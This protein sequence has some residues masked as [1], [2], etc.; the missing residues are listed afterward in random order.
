MLLYFAH[1][2][3]NIRRTRQL[4]REEKTLKSFLDTVLRQM[5]GIVIRGAFTSLQSTTVS[6]TWGAFHCAKISGN[7]GRN[8]NGTLGSRRKFSGKSGPPPE[9]VLFD[10]SIRSDRNLPFRFEKFSLT[11]PLH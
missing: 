6:E 10:R 5:G 1:I 3:C 2:I 9:V 11:V 4:S 7:F 8:I